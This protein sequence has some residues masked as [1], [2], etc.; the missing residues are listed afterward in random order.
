FCRPQWQQPSGTHDAGPRRRILRHYVFRRHGFKRHGFPRDHEWHPDHP[1][2]LYRSQWRLSGSASAVGQRRLFLWHDSNGGV[3]NLGTIFRLSTNGIL[4]T[5][6]T[7][8]GTNG[9][10][11]DSSLN[12]GSDGALYGTTAAGGP[13]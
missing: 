4:T 6:G 7:F 12:V 10:S 3:S 5:L 2:F 13:T 11:P 1:C 9:S 8:F